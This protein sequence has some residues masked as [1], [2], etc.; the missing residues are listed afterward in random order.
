MLWCFT[1]TYISIFIESKDSFCCLIPI[2]QTIRGVMLLQPGYHAAAYELCL[3]S[4]NNE[5]TNEWMNA[6]GKTFLFFYL[7]WSVSFVVAIES[8]P[9]LVN[10]SLKSTSG[11]IWIY[12]FF[13]PIDRNVL[14][15]NP[16]STNIGAAF[17]ANS[18]RV[19]R[20]CLAFF[21]FD[22]ITYGGNRTRRCRNGKRRRKWLQFRRPL[23]CKFKI[24][25]NYPGEM[26]LER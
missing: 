22:Q 8:P 15:E 21:D 6:R 4:S 20:P 23:P 2:N 26:C 7:I 13:F 3:K 25:W 18:T 16:P 14:T 12:R 9:V 1:L 11:I 10:V 19:L 24:L 17:S 5:R